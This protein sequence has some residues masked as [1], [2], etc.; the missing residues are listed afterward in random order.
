[1][2]AVNDSTMV[3][4]TNLVKEGSLFLY[5]QIQTLAPQLWTI[6]RHRVLVDNIVWLI[7]STMLLLVSILGCV[8]LI[9]LDDDDYVP[10]IVIS[11]GATVISGIFACC[12]IVE[13]ATLDYA[14]LKAIIEVVK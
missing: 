6:T 10:G 8:V 9:K 4:I 11:M 12:Y 7:F 14:T 1:M 2:N 5:Q 3:A 13:L